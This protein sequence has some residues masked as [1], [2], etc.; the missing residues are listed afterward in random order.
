MAKQVLFFDW[1]E[2]VLRQVVTFLTQDRPGRLLDLS[3][4]LL[5]VPTRHAGR[6]LREA[7]ALAMAERSGAVLPG[8]VDTPSVVFQPALDRKVAAEFVESIVWCETLRTLN[9]TDFPALWPTAPE[10]SDPS[11]A[12]RFSRPFSRLR[13]LLC[14]EGRTVCEIAA[15]ISSTGEA[16]R[17]HDLARLEDLYLARLAAAGW[18]D[19]C[20]ERLA[21]SRASPPAQ[22]RR[23]V[24]L[25]APDPPPLAIQTLKRWAEELDL[26]VCVHAPESERAAFDEWGRPRSEIWGAR[27]LDL[28]ESSLRHYAGPR[29]QAKAAAAVLVAIPPTSFGA[30]AMGI[31]DRNL[32]PFIEAELEALGRSVYDPEGRSAI[33]HPPVAPALAWLRAAVE[34]SAVSL[35]DLLREPDVLERFI[36]DPRRALSE[37]DQLR[38]AHLPNSLE[39]VLRV[40]KSNG[41]LDFSMLSEALRGIVPLLG[42]LKTSGLGGELLRTLSEVYRDRM[43]VSGVPRDERFAEAARSLRDILDAFESVEPGLPASCRKPFSLLLAD[44]L[45]EIRLYP[46][47]KPDAIDLLGWLE[48][49]WEDAPVL[50]VTGLT[51]GCVPETVTADPFL[52]G[53]ARD[54]LGLRGNADRFARDLYLLTAMCR[55]RSP[56]ALIVFLG[57]TDATGEPM[58]PSRLLLRCAPDQLPQRVLRLFSE[59]EP[60]A[61]SPAWSRAWKLTPPSL[62]ALSMPSRFSVTELRDYLECPFRY[63]LK[64]RLGMKPLDVAPRE[65]DALSFGTA[66]HAA[67]QRFGGNPEIRESVDAGEIARFLCEAAS[68]WIAAQY[69]PNPGL[70]VRLQKDA[71]HSRLTAAA[72]V[73]ARERAA[74]WRIIQVEIPVSLTLAGVELRGRIDR[75]DRHEFSGAVRAIDYKTSETFTPPEE[76][77][78]RSANETHPSWTQTAI[79]GKPKRWTDLQLPLYVRM[80]RVAGFADAGCGY[81]LMPKAVSATEFAPWTGFDTAMEEAAVACAMEVVRRIGLRVFWPPSPH[82]EYDPFETLFQRKLADNL[83]PAWIADAA[84]RAEGAVP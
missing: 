36:S 69:G 19:G 50:L 18:R 32:S 6:R 13:R 12:L 31:P 67:L 81:F 49:H 10:L 55:S 76:I 44:A 28:E 61:P 59:S 34:E 71:M 60:P 43:L 66:C 7:L 83:E 53:G 47:R 15:V 20:Q 23:V 8:R 72:R 38:A 54:A 21:C 74:G 16:V 17:W 80:L 75:L 29:E 2:P 70:A 73:Q 48:L 56:D 78:L 27:D 40:L 64:H 58:K 52:P 77:H 24:L 84:R 9:A 11:A 22:W 41:P 62:S 25:F 63:F 35:G 82:L 46:E 79:F 3:D 4:T 65:M 14:E 68:S 42:R 5:L 39:D 30:V 37:W 33:Y 1:S 57:A 45:R 26:L 51:E